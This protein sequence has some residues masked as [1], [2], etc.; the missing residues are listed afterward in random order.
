MDELDGVDNDLSDINVVLRERGLIRQFSLS[1]IDKL[2]SIEER[3]NRLLLSEA[4]ESPLFDRA[5]ILLDK[6]HIL[7]ESYYLR[8]PMDELERRNSLMTQSSGNVGF[9]KPAETESEPMDMAVFEDV[10]VEEPEA[11]LSR[12]LSSDNGELWR[13]LSENSAVE[14]EKEKDTTNVYCWGR[15]DLAALL[16]SDLERH[17]VDEDVTFLSKRKIVQISSNIYHS[18]AITATGELYTCGMNDEGQVSEDL[19]QPMVVKPRLVESLLHHRICVVACGQYHTVCVTATGVVLS[20]GGNEVGQLGHSPGTMRCTQPKVMDGLGGKFATTSACG[21]LYSLVLTTTGEVYSCGIGPCAGHGHGQ[22]STR[23]ERIDVLASRSVRAMTAGAYHAACLCVTGEVYVW[24]DGN[25]GQLGVNALPAHRGGADVSLESSQTPVLLPLPTGVGAAAG[26]AAG[27]S[28]TLIWTDTGVLLGCGSNKYGQ[29]GSVSLPRVYS[30]QSLSLPSEHKCIAAVCGSN[31]SLIMVQNSAGDGQNIVMAFGQNTFNQCG[32]SLESE[33]ATIRTPS[34]V[35]ALTDKNIISIAA[36]GDQSFA[37]GATFSA[38]SITELLARQYSTAAT[39]QPV[40]LS[41]STILC[42]CN[43]CNPPDYSDVLYRVI[44][45]FASPSLLG[46]SFVA[47]DTPLCL[48]VSGLEACYAKLIRLGETVIARLLS[49]ITLAILDIEHWE[50]GSADN[51]IRTLLILWQC[52]L[53][54]TI[55]TTNESIMTRIAAVVNQLSQSSRNLLAE[56]I[57]AYPSH[58]FASRLLQPLQTQLSYALR[59]YDDNKRSLLFCN[60][61]GWLYLINLSSD[62]VRP[63]DFYNVAVNE[64]SEEGLVSYY[65]RWRQHQQGLPDIGAPT[66]KNDSGFNIC[67]YSFLFSVTTKRKLLMAETVFQQRA[68]QQNALRNVCLQGS[69]VVFPFLVLH[70]NRSNLLQSTLNQIASADSTDLTKPLKICFVGE[71]GVDEGGVRKEF[72]QLLC[73][74]LFDLQYGMFVPVN[75]GREL[76][77]NRDCSWSNDEFRLIGLLVALAVYN[78]TIL[79]VSLP[80]AVYRKLLRQQMTLADVGSIDRELS[81]GLSKLLAY[82]PAE[83]VQDV[84]CLTFEVTWEDLGL[85][86]SHELIPNGANIPV[87][88]EN[89]ELYVDKYVNWLLV[90]SVSSQFNEFLTG[91]SRVI[92]PSMMSM[93]RAEELEQLVAGVP[94]LDF[95]ALEKSTEYIAPDSSSGWGPEHP[96]VKAFWQVIHSLPLA[97]QQKFLMFSTGSPKAPIGGLAKLAFKI[98]RMGPD[99]DLLPTSHTCFNVLLLPEYSS[100]DKMR[101]RLTKA[102]YECE[103]FGLK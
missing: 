12:L 9:T 17:N 46:G 30:L 20:F 88:H 86:K 24:G 36:G 101:D 78:G 62:K 73:A 4:Q 99:S 90:Q 68:A 22:N 8:V 16:H 80:L 76:W 96:T 11:T 26:V 100:V 47:P 92:S 77:F 28:H 40:P 18:A 65:L 54:T 67:N 98:Q 82:S 93:F 79:D 85:K 75:D 19:S 32:Q 25:S 1:C 57:T 64:M 39:Q 60:A 52:P 23:A 21:D 43:S 6:T 87:T 3:L 34:V 45:L 51:A 102:I 95:K 37:I 97:E 10:R 94:H 55:S 58:L 63:E 103:G 33:W 69:G 59:A 83:E 29:L 56:A 48:D 89:R 71:E 84:F 2:N 53:H 81:S 13:T 27:Y 14:L 61:I 15:F 41:A 35:T 50:K 42:I 38:G 66:I 91:F 72:F 5:K 7:K 31:H 74:Q 44:P 70:V 49:A